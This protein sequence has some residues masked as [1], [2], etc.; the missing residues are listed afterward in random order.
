MI[1]ET[2]DVNG[3]KG[4][5]KTMFSCSLNVM[6]QGKTSIKT[7]GVGTSVKLG[8]GEEVELAGIKKHPR[9]HYLLD[10]LAHAF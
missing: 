6:N 1:K 8:G 3:E 9:S 5:G 4:G 2:L 7:R 10:Q